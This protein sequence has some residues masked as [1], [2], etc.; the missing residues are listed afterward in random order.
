MHLHHPSLS[1]NGKRKGKVKFASADAKRKS[2][3][4]DKE[5]KELLKRQGV[6]AEDRKR[7]RSLSA[8]PLVYSLAVPEG[9]SNKHIKSLNSGLG[10]ATLAPPK[11]YTGNEMIGIGQLHKSNAIPVFRKS[12]AEDLARM[13][14]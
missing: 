3:Q 6:E 5:W 10:V 7:Q 4:L 11:V 12:D 14:R 1:L 13:R 2:E 9:R 8:E